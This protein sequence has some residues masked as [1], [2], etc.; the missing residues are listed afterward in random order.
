MHVFNRFAFK[1]L[2]N[3]LFEILSLGS[4][5]KKSINVFLFTL[6]VFTLITLHRNDNDSGQVGKG[7]SIDKI[8]K[9]SK[10]IL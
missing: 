4:K 2:F 5:L 10:I 7:M 8:S 3:A 9:V 6:T 1:Y